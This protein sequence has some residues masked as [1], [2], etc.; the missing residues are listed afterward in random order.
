M[1]EHVRRSY[2]VGPVLGLLAALLVLIAIDVHG[3]MDPDAAASL[4][5]T[6]SGAD[7]LDCGC[8]ESRTDHPALPDEVTLIDDLSEVAPDLIVH[9]WGTFTTIA[10]LGGSAI[11]WRPLAGPSDLPSFVYTNADPGTGLRHGERCVGCNHFGCLCNGACAPGPGDHGPKC[12]CKMC[13]VASVRME[14][15]VIY[16]YTPREMVVDVHVGFP[17]GQITEWYPKARDVGNGIHWGGVQLLPDYDETFPTEDAPSHYYPARE[18]DATPLRLC[19]G[20]YEHEK[21]LFYRGVGDFALPLNVTLDGD[22]L[23]IRRTDNAPVGQVIVFDNRDG[24]AGWSIVS[25]REAATTVARPDVLPLLERPLDKLFAELQAMIEA[26]GL[27]T[28]EAESMLATWEDSWFEPGLRVLYLVPTAR[29]EEVLPLS[30]TPRPAELARVLVGRIEVITRD[31][32]AAMERVVVDLHSRRHREGV[33]EYA[34]ALKP[35]G[36]FAGPILERLEE[37]VASR[38]GHMTEAEREALI[39]MIHEVIDRAK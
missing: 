34:I 22:V 28:R 24:H 21:F 9:E 39:R 4:T 29:V 5:E 17:K 19:N 32:L 37:D 33:N 7:V 14:T 31:M 27:Y 18:T 3:R 26:Q 35:W 2:F 30:I 13:Y 36:R 10:G 16:F 25:T 15:P 12:V 1:P 11:D 20:G 8:G 38:D 6:R 23:T